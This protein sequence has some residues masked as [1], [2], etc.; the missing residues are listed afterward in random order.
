MQC[1]ARY[2]DEV[3]WPYAARFVTDPKFGFALDYNDNLIVI[4]MCVEL[5]V[6]TCTGRDVRSDRLSVTYEHTLD[7]IVL[8]RRVGLKLL[9]DLM[10]I[11]EVGH[12]CLLRCNRQVSRDIGI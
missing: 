3:P 8:G 6:I 7:W 1:V 11:Y 4:G 2:K 12:F 9:N 10:Q 5:A